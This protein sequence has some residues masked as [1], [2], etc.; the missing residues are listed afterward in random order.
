MFGNLPESR[1][2]PQFRI[3]GSM[4]SV[5]AHAMIIGGAVVLTANA[6]LISEVVTTERIEPL[7]SVPQPV[8]SAP[9]PVTASAASSTVAAAGTP[10]LIVPDV[11]PIDLP[12]IELR[13]IAPLS[14]DIIGSSRVG[15]VDGIVGGVNSPGAV[16]IVSGQP[17]T[18]EQVDKPVVLR[19]GSPSPEY[20]DA[21][22]QAGVT[23]LVVVQFVVDSTG[24]V[25]DGSIRIMQS[26]HEQFSGRVRATLPRMRF[27]PAEYQGRKVPQLVQLPFRFDITP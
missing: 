11:V 26:A 27:L 20:P 3:G 6:Q 18:A 1:A 9:R 7:V 21:L 8:Q 15:R 19:P 13:A 2:R 24:R 25:Q 12:A 23:G 5:A 16:G 17:F 22:R 4:A 14:D 10:S